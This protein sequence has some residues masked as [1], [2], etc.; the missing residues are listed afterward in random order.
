MQTVVVRGPAGVV[1]WGYHVAASL[2]PWTL[3]GS[4]LTAPIQTSDAF[5]LSQ[6]PLAFV[7]PRPAGYPWRWPILSL[8]VVDGA[9]TATLGPQE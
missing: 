6:Q 2:G 8:Q 7:V 1:E 3:D 9:L 4:T 5:A